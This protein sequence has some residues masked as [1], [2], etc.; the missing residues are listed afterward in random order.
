MEIGIVIRARSASRPVAL[1][2]RLHQCAAKRT[3]AHRKQSRAFQKTSAMRHPVMLNKH[4]F[5]TFGN[6]REALMPPP[7]SQH[8]AK[9]RP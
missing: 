1:R 3:K 2:I 7:S 8:P 4:V 5:D 9:H 6:A